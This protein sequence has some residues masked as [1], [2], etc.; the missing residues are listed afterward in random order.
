MPKK[1]GK[2]VTKILLVVVVIAIITFGVVGW[3]DGILG[4]TPCGDINDLSVDSGTTVRVRGEITAIVL[5]VVTLSD[6]TGG[7]AF[8][9]TGPATV[10]S[11]VVVTGV[12]QSAHFLHLVSSVEVVWIFQ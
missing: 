6:G 8:S 3:H 2:P 9:W 4:V 5:F 12:V 7:V 10:G 11:I 1:K